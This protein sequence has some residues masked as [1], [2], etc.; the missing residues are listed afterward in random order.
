MIELNTTSFSIEIGTTNG[1]ATLR[2]NSF[3]L[4][5]TFTL[6]MADNTN[7]YMLEVLKTSLTPPPPEYA[8]YMYMYNSMYVY[9]YT[10]T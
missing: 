10:C 3:T 8:L 5:N 9:N 6:K 7:N 1:T 2:H 4:N